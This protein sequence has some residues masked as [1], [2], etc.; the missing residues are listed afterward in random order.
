V[1]LD[2]THDCSHQE[3]MSLVLCCVEKDGNICKHFLTFIPVEQTTSQALA[4]YLLKT[5]DN[6]ELSVADIRGQGYDNGSNMKG[7]V[8]GVQARILNIN[9]RVFHVS[10][11][12]HSWNLLLADVAKSCHKAIHFFHFAENLCS[13]YMFNPIT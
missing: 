11:T 9:K 12:C 13:F 8:A 10:C 2:C 3:Q 1:I 5:L 4:E 7:K 6:Y